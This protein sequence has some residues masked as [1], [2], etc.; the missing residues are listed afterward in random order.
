MHSGRKH[1]LTVLRPAL[2]ITLCLAAALRHSLAFGLAWSSPSP[3]G[4]ADPRNVGTLYARTAPG[5]GQIF[6]PFGRKT[7]AEPVVSRNC[8]KTLIFRTMLIRK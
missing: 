3:S 8:N 1:N 6:R 4:R 2:R 7:S 5:Y